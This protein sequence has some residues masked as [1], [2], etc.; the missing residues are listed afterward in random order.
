MDYN[1]LIKRF[2]SSFLLI[3]IFVIFLF[4]LSNFL[5]LLFFFLFFIFI[6]YLFFIFVIFLFYLLIFLWLFFFFIYFI[7]M[8][9]LVTLFKKNN[10][11]SIY[12]YVLI[13]FILLQIYFY[14][15]FDI[16]EFLFVF[17]I[18]STFDTASYFFG[19][20]F[21]KRKIFK[22]IS[23]KKSYE[24]LLGGTIISFIISMAVNNMFNIFSFNNSL[25]FIMIIITLS[26]TGDIIESNIKRNSNIKNSS[27]FLPGHGGFFDR[28]DGFILVTYGLFFYNLI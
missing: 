19:T 16:N 14:Y 2:L 26:F 1:I 23:P 8:Y 12:L 21:G 18:I 6:F 25:L 11:Y 28:F 3:F 7:I 4:Y 17:I 13:S 5:W 20:F 22:Q 24:G 10:I 15:Y 27:N 9:E